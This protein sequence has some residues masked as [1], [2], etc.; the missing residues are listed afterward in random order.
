MDAHAPRLS[1]IQRDVLGLFA[2]MAA[3][4]LAIAL[5]VAFGLD[6]SDGVGSVFSPWALALLA[7]GFLFFAGSVGWWYYV[8]RDEREPAR[9]EWTSDP[10]HGRFA[11]REGHGTFRDKAL[12]PEA[13]DEPHVRMEADARYTP[14]TRRG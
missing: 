4:L 9:G 5:A 13:M 2:P 6:L 1:P 12:A 7:L 10:D 11:R 3:L 14:R 8:Y